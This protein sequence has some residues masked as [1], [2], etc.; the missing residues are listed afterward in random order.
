MINGNLE[1]FLDTGWF[2]ESTLYLNGFIYFCAAY[3]KDN[4]RE[5][6]VYKWRATN[7]DNKYFH[8]ICNDDNLV[9]WERVYEDSDCNLDLIK[10]RFLEARIFDGKSFWE[11]ESEIAWLDESTPIKKDSGS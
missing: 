8:S 11:V 1:Q 3:A 6:S 2:S 10:K 7:E 4:N 5:Y 9:D